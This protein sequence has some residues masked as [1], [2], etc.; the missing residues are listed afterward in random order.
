MLVCLYIYIYIYI[1]N[2]CVCMC[3]CVCALTHS[4]A[5]SRNMLVI[6]GAEIDQKLRDATK[7]A[8]VLG[9]PAPV[10]VRVYLYSVIH[11]DFFPG[12]VPHWIRHYLRLGVPAG[13]HN[14]RNAH[15]HIHTHT[16]TRIHPPSLSHKFQENHRNIVKRT[17]ET[18][19]HTHPCSIVQH[20]LKCLCLCQR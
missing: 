11:V 7:R 19:P 2:V 9:S 15:I 16:H 10:V 3:V 5:Q 12:L 20:C 6:S 4:P 1:Y 8:E 17:T 18:Q 13:M 14:T